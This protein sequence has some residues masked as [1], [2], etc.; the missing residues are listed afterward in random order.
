MS[1]DECLTL[2]QAAHYFVIAA[3]EIKCSEILVS[4]IDVNCN[5]SSIVTCAVE[6]QLDLLL[7]QCLD[8]MEVNARKVLNS[9]WFNSLPL[10][11]ILAFVKS[12]NLEVRV[13]LAVA[14]WYRHQDD[15][16]S[17]DDKKQVFQLT[18]YPLMSS[19]DLL[20]QHS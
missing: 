6:Q 7:T 14:R 18:R 4:T 13:F 8:F 15:V 10:R 20:D 3:W 17:A 1:C 11:M 9:P 12:S 5:F 16:L 19:T 2:Q